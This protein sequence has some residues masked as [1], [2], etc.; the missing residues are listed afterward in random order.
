MNR[1][2]KPLVSVILIV[3]NGERYLAS[4]INSVLN[5]NYQPL[6]IVVV[7][8]HS[9]DSTAEIAK[10]F[11]EVRYMLQ[12]NQGIANAYNLGIDTAEGE[13]IAF[14]SHDDL[15]AANKLQLQVEY[16]IAH[17]EVE[18]TVSKFQ[19]FLAEGCSLPPGFKKELLEQDHVGRIME[20]LVAR[21]TVFEKVGK[22]NPDYKLAEDVDWYAR[23][24]DQNIPMAVI[25]EVLL[26]KRVHNSNSSSDAEV[27]NQALLKLL[28]QSI[29]RQRSQKV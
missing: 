11:T 26:Y 10:S 27:S 2:N 6:E 1:M 25:P 23:A 7:D 17:P 13:L 4:A 16:L 15:W 24:K 20:T 5:C 28:R 29:N 14:I 9:T 18:Y 19:Y 12:T 21:K 8:G 22:F 3:K